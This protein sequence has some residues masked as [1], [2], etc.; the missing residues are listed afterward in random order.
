KNDPKRAAD[1]YGGERVG[2]TLYIDKDAAYNTT[3]H[4]EILHYYTNPDF[5]KVFAD[6]KG[7]RYHEGFTE[8]FA[9]KVAPRAPGDT[10]HYDGEV[11]LTQAIAD[12]V[13]EEVMKR[14]YFQ[15]DKEAF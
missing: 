15:G 2:T 10:G 6:Y 7:V 3:L 8:Y 1:R 4:H 14:A 11:S 12:A 13:G 5:E 9:R